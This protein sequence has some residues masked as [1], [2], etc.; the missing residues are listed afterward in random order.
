MALI[1]CPEC[2][3]MV[4]PNADECPECGAPVTAL[5]NHSCGD[6]EAPTT[7]QEKAEPQIVASEQNHII[8][9][10]KKNRKLI[11]ILIAVFLVLSIIANLYFVLFSNRPI[12]KSEQPIT[13]NGNVF[14][15]AN[16]E[17]HSDKRKDV[18]VAEVTQENTN[19]TEI[20]QYDSLI[21]NEF[22]QDEIIKKLLVDYCNAIVDNDFSKL[23]IL[24]AP[25]VERFQSAYE[26]SREEVLEHHRKYDKTFKVYGKHSSIRWETFSMTKINDNRVEAIII[27]DYSIDRVD[28]S[29]YSIFV[30]EK[31]FTINDD[32]QIVSVW[33]NQLSKQKKD[34]QY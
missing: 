11:I 6:Q 9:N 4:S 8:N 15:A 27:E 33:D 3:R 28:N 14:S 1:P 24:Y 25:H 20:S 23:S 5:L 29:K 19:T 16:T 30:L 21:T 32:Y 18:P 34:E 7:E 22:P 2:G 26:E 31:H 13:Q 10:S 12:C 17:T